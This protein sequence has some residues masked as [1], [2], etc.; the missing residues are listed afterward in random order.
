M[1]R[2][3]PAG[4][5]S[6]LASQAFL[7][8]ARDG[9]FTFRARPETL[10][11][12]IYVRDVLHGFASLLA[13]PAAGLSRRVDNIAGMTATPWEIAVAIRRRLPGAVLDFQPD[14]EVERLLAGGP[15]AIDDSMAR[16]DW[17]WRPGWDLERMADD[18]LAAISA[19]GHTTG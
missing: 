12:L 8:A 1:A 19:G 11:A 3:A 13:A 17:H 7:A 2:H 18:F 6:A 14:D 4:A 16:R 10:L 5:A 9:R 15:G